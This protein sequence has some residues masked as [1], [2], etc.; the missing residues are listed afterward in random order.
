MDNY[1]KLT[2]IPFEAG[3]P[4]AVVI[5]T[6]MLRGEAVV[7]GRAAVI[8]DR[9]EVVTCGIP[10]SGPVEDLFVCEAALREFKSLLE[11]TS[12]EPVENYAGQGIA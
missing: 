8:D 11:A 5:A 1:C 7:V 9:Y 2:R 3:K 6:V 12:R 10:P 4:R